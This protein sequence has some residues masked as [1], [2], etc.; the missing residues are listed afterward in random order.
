MAHQF[1]KFD[2]GS[3]EN[4]PLRGQ[5]IITAYHWIWGQHQSYCGFWQFLGHKCVQLLYFSEWIFSRSC[6]GWALIIIFRPQSQS[7]LY[8]YYYLGLQFQN[9]IIE[10]PQLNSDP[11]YSPSS[12]C[13]DGSINTQP[14]NQQ[15]CHNFELLL[16]IMAKTWKSS[17]SY[18][19]WNCLAIQDWCPFCFAPKTL[20]CLLSGGWDHSV[21][22]LALVIPQSNKVWDDIHNHGINRYIY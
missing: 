12:S 22:L 17:R 3:W 16:L 18:L 4:S 7:L 21:K 20:V 14:F 8:C 9:C 1:V 11:V 5:V 6:W 13:K 19:Q 10:K 15:N 2:R